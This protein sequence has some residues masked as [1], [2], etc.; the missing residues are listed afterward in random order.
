MTA[1]GLR[2]RLRATEVAANMTCG[3]CS[4]T[5]VEPVGL[6]AETESPR[7]RLL[8]ALAEIARRNAEVGD[9]VEAAHP[10][11]LAVAGA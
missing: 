2:S 3:R 11:P 4:G 7:D 9:L 10:P 5:G 6:A 8:A 1:G